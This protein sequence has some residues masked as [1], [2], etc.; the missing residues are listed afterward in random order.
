MD[1]TK[2]METPEATQE[3]TLNLKQWAYD[4]LEEIAKD[5]GETVLMTIYE[6]IQELVE[7]WEDLKAAQDAE[8][9]DEPA[10][11]LDQVIRRLEL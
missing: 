4:V 8:D 2:A 5:K 1:A 3:I 6:A 11:T 7:D 10:Y 9:R